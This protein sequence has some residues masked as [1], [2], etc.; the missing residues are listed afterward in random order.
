LES[1]VKIPKSKIAEF[2]R[3]NHIRKLSIF[4][5]V[6]HESFGPDS[7]IDV[8]VE[9][10]PD[11]MPGFALIRMQAELSRLLG[12]RKLDLVTTKFLNRRIRS[13]VEAEAQVQYVQE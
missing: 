12:G 6:L 4:G 2:C 1:K 7:D 8:L 11:H 3:Q 9:F 13:Q 10:D 5:S